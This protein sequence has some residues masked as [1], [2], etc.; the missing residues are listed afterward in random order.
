MC[1]VILH[2]GCTIEKKSSLDLQIMATLHDHI[3]WTDLDCNQSCTSRNILRP[4]QYL[5]Q[6]SRRLAGWKS[7]CSQR[8][9]ATIKHISTKIISN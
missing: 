7:T 8:L 2:A 3:Q 5:T 4:E 6:W 9:S 1:I